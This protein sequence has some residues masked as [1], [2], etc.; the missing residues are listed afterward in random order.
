MIV[1]FAGL[2]GTGKTTLARALADHLTPVPVLLLDKDGTRRTL[3]GAALTVYDRDQDDLVVDVLYQAA[4]WQVRRNPATHVIL[5]GRTYSRAYQVA[6]VRHLAAGLDQR[7]LIVE[8]VCDRPTALARLRRDHAA[9][10]HPAADRTPDLHDRLRATADPIHEPK[11]VLHTAA[12][13]DHTLPQV[14]AAVTDAV[15]TATA[16]EDR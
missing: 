7:L 5:D 3:F 1:A 14:I 15:T 16:P 9:G 4:A 2:P 11:L 10:A 13:L 8:C 6:Q 12:P